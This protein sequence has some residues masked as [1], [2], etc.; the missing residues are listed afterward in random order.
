MPIIRNHLRR[1]SVSSS[2]FLFLILLVGLVGS[3]SL[4]SEEREDNLSSSAQVVDNMLR[5]HHHPETES[6]EEDDD[7][8]TN[9]NNNGHN[10]QSHHD[11]MMDD[12]EVRFV[13][14]AD[15]FFYEDERPAPSQSSRLN[16][17]SHN[18]GE[19]R[20][21]RA[22]FERCPP[23]PA[24]P[25]ATLA[26]S[27]LCSAKTCQRDDEC[28]RD[29]SF[30]CCYNGCVYSCLPRVNHPLAFDWVD[31]TPLKFNSMTPGDGDEEARG[32]S[33]P[34][35][36]FNAEIS[37]ESITLPGGCYLNPKQ[38][39]DLLLFRKFDHVQT[40]SCSKGEVLCEVTHHRD[41]K[42]TPG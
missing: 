2:L 32:G 41:L 26:G 34:R 27:P 21:N 6:A 36:L 9:N 10:L 38:Y 39:D 20:D 8:H 13:T 24:D 40:C 17:E 15:D 30:I 28:S 4:L 11:Y 3:S 1:I 31:E 18:R 19:G 25:S 7:N 42:A 37:P 16:Q 23:L 29:G 33:R 5:L 35:A 12:E 14:E 22:F